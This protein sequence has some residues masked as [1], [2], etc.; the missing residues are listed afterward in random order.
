MV[1]GWLMSE[2]RKEMLIQDVALFLCSQTWYSSIMDNLQK[3]TL[4]YYR[5]AAIYFAIGILNL[6][7]AL[8]SWIGISILIFGGLAAMVVLTYLPN[9]L[10]RLTRQ[11]RIDIVKDYKFPA[12]IWVV[13]ACICGITAWF[14]FVN[15][16]PFA[17]SIHL[18][19]TAMAFSMS[20][21]T[22]F[23]CLTVSR[24]S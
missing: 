21:L 4:H 16:V 11:E 6:S 7:L 5:G 9:P 20:A 12:T 19:A 2:F 14:G 10:S 3:I 17:S 24:N 1:F 18:V 8:K 22:I 15:L 13:V 23:Y